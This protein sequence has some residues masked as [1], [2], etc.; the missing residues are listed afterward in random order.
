MVIVLGLIYFILEK[1]HE[2]KLKILTSMENR[3]YKRKTE[4]ALNAGESL[5][6]SLI[7]NGEIEMD[8]EEEQQNGDG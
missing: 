4:L 2:F 8:E 3:E 1:K 7:R 5:G 6:E